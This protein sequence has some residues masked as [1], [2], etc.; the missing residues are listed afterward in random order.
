MLAIRDLLAWAPGSLANRENRY[1][2]SGSYLFLDSSCSPHPVP[3]KLTLTGLFALHSLAGWASQ[4]P[5]R[6]A[7]ESYCYHSCTCRPSSACADE[8]RFTPAARP[9]L[10]VARWG[11]AD[12]SWC[13]RLEYPPVPRL[14]RNDSSRL[15]VSV[16]SDRTDRHRSTVGSRL[17][18]FCQHLES[19]CGARSGT[20]PGNGTQLLCTSF[21]GGQA[22]ANPA[23]R[24]TLGSPR[25]G[26]RYTLSS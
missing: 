10:T 9:N 13:P 17:Q 15:R 16:C 4:L 7:N 3:R 22:P 23:L 20:V 1:N 19:A 14:F 2:A 26:L 18:P 24:R 6:T 12:A 11:T 8:H 5:L 21:P 25:S